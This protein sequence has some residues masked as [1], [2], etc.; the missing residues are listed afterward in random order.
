MWLP[1]WSKYLLSK[2]STSEFILN[3]YVCHAWLYNIN[4]Y[5][6]SDLEN[7]SNT[8]HITQMRSSIWLFIH[9]HHR[10]W[11]A[12]ATKY[13][14]L[15][16]PSCFL[17]QDRPNNFYS[18]EL[19]CFCYYKSLRDY[20]LVETLT[21]APPFC[22]TLTAIASTF[23][24]NQQTFLPSVK[25]STQSLVFPATNQDE[26]SYRT[27]TVTNEGK[28]PVVYDFPDMKLVYSWWIE[29]MH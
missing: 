23:Q 14:S 28:T 2:L 22:L 8:Q 25:L 7:P 27:I 11:M 26:P 1:L 20:R 16:Y 6:N 9:Y 4:L 29:N 15:Y 24:Q 17:L 12:N 3:R 5:V 13:L 21:H 18:N 19:E 10:E